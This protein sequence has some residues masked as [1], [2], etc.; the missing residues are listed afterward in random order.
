MKS[1]TKIYLQRLR[2]YYSKYEDKDTLALLDER[3]T[4]HDVNTRQLKIFRDHPKTQELIEQMYG[5]LRT[6][7]EKLT[8]DPNMPEVDRR[9]YFVSMDWARWFLDEVGEKP[10]VA[11]SEFDKLVE[12]YAKRAGLI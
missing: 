10:E 2:E 1:R 9:A 4:D 12:G 11:D 8:S 3:E 7:I 5:R 6:A